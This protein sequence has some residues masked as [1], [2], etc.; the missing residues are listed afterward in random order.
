MVPLGK[1]CFVVLVF[2]IGF[3]IER[4]S[5]SAVG[6]ASMVPLGMGGFV[7]LV[8]V[9]VFPIERSSGSLCVRQRHRGGFTFPALLSCGTFS[10]SPL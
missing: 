5:G 4:S 3:P 6:S 9:I 7:V 10:G 1:C 2:V 8:F